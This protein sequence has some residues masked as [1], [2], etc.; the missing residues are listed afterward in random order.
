MHTQRRTRI[1][2]SERLIEALTLRNPITFNDCCHSTQLGFSGRNGWQERH[3]VESYFKLRRGVLKFLQEL[4]RYF[5]LTIYT[6][7][8]QEH[9]DSV[10]LT[11][12]YLILELRSV[13][14]D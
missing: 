7:G 13:F 8:T 6:A 14:D 1:R 3:L 2:K 4:S 10:S 5:E 9:A 12:N 11:S